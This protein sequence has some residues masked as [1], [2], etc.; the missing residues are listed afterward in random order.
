MI[1]R[2]A[3]ALLAVSSLAFALAAAPAKAADYT[4]NWELPTLQGNALGGADFEDA[5]TGYAAG[6]R[7]TV[8]VTD[9][10]GVTWT[11]RELFPMFSPDLEDVLVIGPGDLLA[12]GASPGV[13][14]STDAGA[15]WTAVPNPSFAK[16]IDI[17]RVSGAVLSAIGVEGQVLRSENHGATWTLLASPGVEELHEQYW[18]DAAAPAFRSPEV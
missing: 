9:D 14:R 6:P 18:S 4:F 1:K 11:P 17:E 8:L 15:S 16:L 13:F 5:A 2:A 3:L 10:G 7:G 12:V